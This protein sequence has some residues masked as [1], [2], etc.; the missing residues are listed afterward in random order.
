MSY[1]CMLTQVGRNT[2]IIKAGPGWVHGS[3]SSVIPGQEGERPHVWTW[4]SWRWGFPG[5]SRSL[6][7]RHPEPACSTSLEVQWDYHEERQ[8]KR[9]PTAPVFISIPFRMNLVCLEFCLLW[10]FIIALKG[11]DTTV[12]AQRAL[13]HWGSLI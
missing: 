1:G 3:G 8:S 5:H 12:T 11:N 9:T 6:G 10:S 2:S 4:D 7:R 13:L